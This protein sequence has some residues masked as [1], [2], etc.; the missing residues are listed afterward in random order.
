[1]GFEFLLLKKTISYM[2]F[3]SNTDLRRKLEPYPRDQARIRPR[4]PIQGVSAGTGLH[5]QFAILVLVTTQHQQST[6]N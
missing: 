5:K 2:T 3:F 6:I 4:T 1:M